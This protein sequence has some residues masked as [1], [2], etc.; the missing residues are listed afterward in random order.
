MKIIH[1]RIFL[2]HTVYQLF[3][4]GNLIFIA[5]FVGFAESEEDDM[6][7]RLADFWF[8]K[9]SFHPSTITP[10]TRSSY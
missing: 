8:A 4:S 9:S 1:A 7:S 3:F 2:H 5:L 10:V 6:I